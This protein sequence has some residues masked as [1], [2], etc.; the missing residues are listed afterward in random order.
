[1]NKRIAIPVEDGVMSS[2]FGH[3]KTFVFIDVVEGNM[4]EEKHFTP[5][6]HE[7][8]SLPNWLSDMGST[9]VMVGGIGSK[10]EK[11]LSDKDI[12]IHKG[13]KVKPPS[14]LVEDLLKNSLELG[15]HHCDH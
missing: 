9:E 8:G 15:I 4:M 6:P 13:L 14:S 5:P 11:I 7:P 1:M 12:K 2:H 3:A 10:A